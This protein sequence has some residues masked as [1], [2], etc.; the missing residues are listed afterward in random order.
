MN[1]DTDRTT[2]HATGYFADL[3]ERLRAGG[4]PQ[5]QVA[6]TVADLSG[7]LAESGSPDAVEEFGTPAE[8]AARL[9]EG[10]APEQPEAGAQTWKWA[11]D[12]YADRRFLNHYGDQGWEVEGLDRLG[13]FVCHRRPD[14]AMRWEYRRDGA[15]NAKEREA[16]TAGLALE[17]WEPCG[18]WMY[19]LYFKRPKAATAGPAAGLDGL[20]AT[21]DRQLFL[22]RSYRGKLWQF[23]AAAVVSGTASFLALHYGGSGLLAPVLA[24]A[25]IAAPVGVLVACRRLKQEAMAG[26]EDGPA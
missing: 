1:H 22:S 24:G 2:E 20:E 13:R 7:Y 15:G 19:F 21:P 9:L 18:H 23:L 26:A 17:G 25:V 5:E 6:A 12:I 11:A 3:A 14:T 4:L 8:F 10:R 16:V